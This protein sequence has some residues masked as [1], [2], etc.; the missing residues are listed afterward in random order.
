M[1]RFCEIVATNEKTL[2]ACLAFWLPAGL[3]PTTIHVMKKP[4]LFALISLTITITPLCATQSLSFSGPTSWTPGA[5]IVLSTT[6]TYS[7]FGG[8]S[9]AL[10]YWLGVTSALAPFLTITDLTHF[11]FPNGYTGH[12][13]VLFNAAG[14]D[15][16]TY[17]SVD[18]GSGSPVLIPDGS[19]HVTDI[20]FALAPKPPAG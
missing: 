6:D 5:S 14:A 7:G 4:L 3:A 12:D 1:C 2:D 19:Y 9:W 18:L 11:V 8:G 15:G 17:E 13:P 20:T 10:S 16:F